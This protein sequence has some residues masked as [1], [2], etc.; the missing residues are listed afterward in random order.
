[1]LLR[2]YFPIRMQTWLHHV[3]RYDG[4]YYS[5]TLRESSEAINHRQAWIKKVAERIFQV[6]SSWPGPLSLK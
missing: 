2:P 1:M 4:W 6:L 5:D 3:S